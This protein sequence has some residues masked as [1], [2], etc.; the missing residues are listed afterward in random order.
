MFSRFRSNV[1]HF[2]VFDSKAKV[3]HV[4]FSELGYYDGK[5]SK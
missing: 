4:F 5:G 1:F 2:I 3:G